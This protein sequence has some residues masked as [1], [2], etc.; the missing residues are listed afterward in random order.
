MVGIMDFDKLVNQSRLA[1]ISYELMT[2]TDD[3][4]YKFFCESII[5]FDVKTII[6][7][8]LHSKTSQ[9]T[10]PDLFMGKIF[11]GKI[12]GKGAVINAHGTL[13]TD[14]LLPWI[15][16]N[17][18]TTYQDYFLK[19]NYSIN[20]ENFN[21]YSFD[22]KRSFR[23]ISGTV[24]VLASPSDFSYSHFVFES[25]SKLFFVDETWRNYFNNVKIIV[26]DSIKS[27]QLDML[28]S[29]GIDQKNIIQKAIDEIILADEI[30]FVESPSHNNNWIIPP[31]IDF[32]KL[33]FLSDIDTRNRKILKRFCYFDRNDERVTIRPIVNESNLKQVAKSIGFNIVTPGNI[34]VSQKGNIYCH[35]DVM[36]AQYGGGAQLSFLLAPHARLIIFQSPYFKRRM[37]DFIAHIQGQSLI[38]ILGKILPNQSSSQDAAFEINMQ[39]FYLALEFLKIR[40]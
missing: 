8:K 27:Y 16:L 4:C 26:N 28:L 35:T 10:I 19:Q 12:I 29:F 6:N 22:S 21:Q 37:L 5:N 18:P 31:A 14:S 13:L 15:D 24:F 7:N 25:F 23:Y 33:F 38:N 17:S 1:H 9:V 34:A 40:N 20:K 3:V 11:G 30:I 39:D 2:A 32:L 36:I